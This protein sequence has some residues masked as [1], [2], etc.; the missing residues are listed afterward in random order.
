MIGG[1]SEYLGMAIGSHQLSLLVIAAYMGSLLFLL[2]TRRAAPVV[3][4]PAF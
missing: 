3:P 4:V 2:T 1:F